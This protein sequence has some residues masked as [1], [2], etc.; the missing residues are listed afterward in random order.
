MEILDVVLAVEQTC[1]CGSHA[2]TEE[3]LLEGISEHRDTLRNLQGSW[4]RFI[5]HLE[6][7]GVI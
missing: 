7:M 6:D 1:E 3:E 5:A 4:G 2:Y